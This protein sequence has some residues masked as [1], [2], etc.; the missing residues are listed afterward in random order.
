RSVRRAIRILTRIPDDLAVGADRLGLCAEFRRPVPRTVVRA[1][2]NA[3]GTRCEHESDDRDDGERCENERW[4]ADIEPIHQMIPSGRI[5]RTRRTTTY[6]KTT[7][8]IRMIHRR[9]DRHSGVTENGAVSSTTTRKPMSDTTK[10]SSR[11]SDP[12]S[13]NPMIVASIH[14]VWA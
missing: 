8:P 3:R 1:K 7:N 10:N 4:I 14:A 11:E 6:P 12:R 5:A 13:A 2:G 9:P